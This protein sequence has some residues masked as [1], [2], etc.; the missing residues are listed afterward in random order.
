MFRRVHGST[1]TRSR[2]AGIGAAIAVSLGAGGIG[3]IAHAAN[4]SPSSFVPITPCR[5]FDTRPAPANVGDRNTPLGAGEDLLRQ[6]TGTNGDCTIPAGTSAIS[7]NLTIPSGVDGFLTL[8]PADA[9]RRPSTSSIN[10]VT[11]QGVKV[12]GG[13]VG[14]SAAGAIKLYTLTGP[15]DA[16]L[17]VTGYFLATPAGP[18]GPSGPAGPVGATGPAGAP[19]PAGPTLVATGL[20]DADG[21]ILFPTGQLPTV[22]HVATGRWSIEMSG[23]GT[24]CPAP[25]LT[26]NGIAQTFYTVGGTCKSGNISTEVRSSDEADGA[27]F[28]YMF[29]RSG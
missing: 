6:V 25:Q 12:N 29:V 16:V 8:Y 5:L 2:W 28:W 20:V 15:I 9:A 22:V 17:D 7:Y 23:F 14:L 11:G 3:F 1:L 10:P 13:I 24:G 4:S 21:A 27:G 19:G 26:S 18:G